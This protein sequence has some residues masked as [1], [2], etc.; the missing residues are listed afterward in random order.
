MHKNNTFTAIG[1]GSRRDYGDKSDDDATSGG[2]R[3]HSTIGPEFGIANFGGSYKQDNVMLLKTCIG[4]RALGW[5]LRA[6][7]AS[8]PELSPVPGNH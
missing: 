2:G 1:A 8:P 5:D 3:G 6:I 4:D 7:L